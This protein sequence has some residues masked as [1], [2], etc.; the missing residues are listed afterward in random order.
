VLARTAVA[1]EQR[2]R[3]A[4]GFERTL[5]LWRLESTRAAARFVEVSLDDPSRP[6][7]RDGIGT[8]R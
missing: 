8:P 3:A 6:G 5:A 2:L 7:N 4:E 1:L